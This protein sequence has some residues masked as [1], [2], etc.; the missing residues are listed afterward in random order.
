M[1]RPVGHP[2]QLLRWAGPVAVLALP[3]LVAM[4]LAPVAS[5]QPTQRPDDARDTGEA[6]KAATQGRASRD[7][8]PGTDRSRTP[9][10]G[11]AAPA[12]RVRRV[13]VRATVRVIDPSADMK[14]IISQMRR[15]R[16][17]RDGR[18]GE[19]GRS[20]RTRHP[21]RKDGK[22]AHGADGQRQRPRRGQHRQG[23]SGRARPQTGQQARREAPSPRRLRSPMPRQA[24]RP[25]ASRAVQDRR[26]RPVTPRRPR[27][28]PA[29]APTRSMDDMRSLQDGRTP[30]R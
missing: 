17:V 23:A 8:G 12:E 19:R 27:T 26:P 3:L 25:S 4:A 29:P 13:K 1:R 9:S 5:A 20:D 18:P 30:S 11:T 6:Q 7:V 16:R 14:D 28:A 2:Q 10:E 22:G 21:V 15:A 24:P